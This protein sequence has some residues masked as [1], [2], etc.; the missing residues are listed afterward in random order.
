M[1][2]EH[3]KMMAEGDWERLK[4]LQLNAFRKRQQSMTEYSIFWPNG[5]KRN[6]LLVI[7]WEIDEYNKCI[8]QIGTAQDITER[9]RLEKKMFDVIIETEEKERNLLAG[10]LHD[11]VGPL[12][13]SLNMYLSMVAHRDCK[14]PQELHTTMSQI[15]EDT[16]VAVREISNNLSPHLLT[17]YGLYPALKDFIESKKH[18]IAFKLNSGI[19][20]NRF[21]IK[22]ESTYFRII[23]ELINNT[24]KYAQAK[25]ILI[26]LQYKNNTLMLTYTDDGS[27]C[28][29][30]EIL[31][32]GHKGIGLLNII[33]R[34]KT[35]NGYQRI[36]SKPGEGFLFELFTRVVN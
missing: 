18:L 9:K 36:A 10:N 14:N 26:N 21:D 12:L 5:S 16:I 11:D 2:E 19:N 7:D 24:L 1:D 30:D 35:I 6:L 28:N 32:S 34:V 29:V 31:N 13:S 3:K 23:K 27:G 17:N 33:S 20:S 4:K 22:I 8:A 25:H 15:L